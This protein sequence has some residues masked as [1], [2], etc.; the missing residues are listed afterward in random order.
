M[1]ESLAHM[2]VVLMV[3]QLDQCLEM[4]LVEQTAYTMAEVLVGCLDIL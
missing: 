4:W 1:E 2:K 3:E